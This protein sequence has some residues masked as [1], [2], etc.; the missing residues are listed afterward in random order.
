VVISTD[1]HSAIDL[2]FMRL[3]VA[4]ASRGWLSASDVFNTRC[5]DDLRDAMRRV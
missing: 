2:E 4:Q 5:L 1:A 3:D